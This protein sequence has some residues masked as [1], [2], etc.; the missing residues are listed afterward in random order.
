MS[1]ETDGSVR[2]EFELVH[3]LDRGSMFGTRDWAAHHVRLGEMQSLKAVA[4]VAG[5]TVLARWGE[6]VPTTPEYNIMEDPCPQEYLSFLFDETE[7]SKYRIEI[8]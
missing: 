1:L 2:D 3:K 4:T 6:A 8:L 7:N 5:E